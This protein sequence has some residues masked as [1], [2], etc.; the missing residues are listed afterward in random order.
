MLALRLGRAPRGAGRLAVREALCRSSLP[1]RLLDRSRAEAALKRWMAGNE[2]VKDLDEK[3]RLESLEAVEFPMW[4]FRT[5]GRDREAV[6]VEPAAPIPIPD[7]ADLEVPAGRLEPYRGA[8]EGAE[9]IAPTIP[10]ATARSWLAERGAGEP[11]ESSLVEV[12]LWRARYRFE[13]ASY[14]ALVEGSTGRVLASVYPE[15]A[16]S[17]YVLVAFL[18]LV[19]FGVLGLAV[20]H[21]LVKLV[22]Y[23]IAA[24][25]LSLVAWWVTRR[26]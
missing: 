2:T 6:T 18:G 7:V 10:L 25:P 9:S 1:P 4:L 23:G 17:P 26:V 16:E 13:G 20:S 15:K 5:G 14:Q 24:V 3:A 19:L 21:P 8:E 11:S 12:P 22:A